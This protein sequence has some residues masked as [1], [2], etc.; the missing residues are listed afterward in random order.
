[1]TKNMTRRDFVKTTAALATASVAATA[2]AAGAADRIRLGII[3]TGNRGTQL[4]AAALPNEDAEFV[5]VC[6]VFDPHIEK[7]IEKIGKKVDT[8]KD[9]RTLLER[10]DI[11]AV[12][13]ATPDH[14]HALQAVDACEAG[15][16]VYVEKPLSV[17]VYEGRRIVEAAR[18]NNRIVQVGT[19]R[20]SSP[21]FAELVQKV[22]DGFIGKITVARCYRLDNMWPNGIGKA[23]DAPP[24]QGLDWDMWLGPRPQRPFRETIAPYKFRWWQAYSSQMANWGVHY[25]DI[26]RWMLNEEAPSSIVAMGGRFAVNDDRDI[27][28]TMEV[29][30]EMP[31]GCLAVFGQYEASGTAA[32]KRGFLELRGTLGTLYVDDRNYEVVPEKGGQFQDEKPRLEP[33]NE[34]RDEQDHTRLHMRNFFDCIKS[35]QTPNG[36]IEIGHRST[37]FCLLANISLAT[38]ARLEWDPAK[39]RFTNPESANQLLHYEYRSPW[40][41]L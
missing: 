14:W 18:R 25:L 29:T 17:T 20:R 13:I 15:K 4:I 9:Y 3:G 16:D 5:A 35:R 32:M 8:C 31:S 39:E 30:Y 2:P 40:K 28:D 10:K 24:P 41:L 22:R 11:D 23:P 26:A 27:P 37:T 33:V 34:K 7:A 12:I 19:Q 38:K 6:D 21:L 36:D 1:M